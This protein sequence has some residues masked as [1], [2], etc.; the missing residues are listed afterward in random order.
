MH[1]RGGTYKEVNI[2][3]IEAVVVLGASTKVESG[4]ITLLSSYNIPLSLISRLGVSILT[5][6]VVTLLSETRRAQYALSEEEKTEIMLR[7]LVAKFRGYANIL[8]YHEKKAPELEVY[9]EAARQDLLRW[10]SS[11]SREYWQLVL[12]LVPKN[13]LNELK[14][15]YEFYGRKPRARDPFNQSVSALYAILYSLAARALLASGLDP[16]CGLHHKTRYSVPLVYDYVEMFKPVAV[17]AVI[18]VL[19]KTSKLLD[20]DEDGYLSKESLNVL[21]K[22]FFNIMRA[23]VRGTKLTPHRAMYVNA[24]R[25]STRIRTSDKNVTYTY[26]YN[27]RKL[28]YPRDVE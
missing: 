8:K 19:R 15:K 20:L 9:E 22:E 27:P 1:R 4:V 10:E 12:D 28:L 18:K 14:E 11:R 6:P 16:T 25:L 23:R 17:H 7:V 26:T 2:R 5:V 24:F 21:L 13:I 3:D